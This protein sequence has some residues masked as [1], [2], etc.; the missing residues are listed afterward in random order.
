[1]IVHD[2]SND[3]IDNCACIDG[4]RKCILDCAVRKVLRLNES[5]LRG[6]VLVLNEVVESHKVVMEIPG[7]L[8]ENRLH[9]RHRSG[10]TKKHR[11]IYE[12]SLI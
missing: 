11:V 12:K 5:V 2:C 10:R 1:M 4:I 6:C 3:K 7:E 9:N 8:H